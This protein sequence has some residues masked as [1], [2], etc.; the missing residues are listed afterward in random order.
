MPAVAFPEDDDEMLLHAAADGKAPFEDVYGRFH[1]FVKSV[2]CRELRDSHAADDACQNAFLIIHRKLQARLFPDEPRRWIAGIA[3][4]CC[5]QLR[6]KHGEIRAVETSYS[7]V[8]EKGENVLEQLKEPRRI[9]T[10]RRPLPKKVADAVNRLTD[11]QRSALLGHYLGGETYRSIAHK[12]GSTMAAVASA[13]NSAL[14]RLR[15][16]FKA[17]LPSE[18]VEASRE[19]ERKR[20]LEALKIARRS[21]A[22]KTQDRAARKERKKV[23]VAQPMRKVLAA[24]AVPAAD[25]LPIDVALKTAQEVGTVISQMRLIRPK[26]EIARARLAAI[27]ALAG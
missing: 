21:R 14:R 13:A 15:D 22:R 3:K 27:E 26:L 24:E 7:S 9:S 23:R 20:S 11:K 17:P 5:R 12:T 18:F 16:E 10:S 1:S 25:L 4:N 19:L 8:G 2:C 6:S